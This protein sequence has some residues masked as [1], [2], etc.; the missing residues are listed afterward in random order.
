MKPLPVVAVVGRPNVGKSALFNRLVGG[1]IAIVE[2]EPGV[3]RDRL[4]GQCRWRGRTF[5]LVDTGGIDPDATEDLAAQSRRHAEL[6]VQEADVI[7]LVVDGQ[8]GV[9]P[10][11]AEVAQLLRRYGKPVVVAVNKIDDPAAPH[12]AAAY[13]FYGL[14]LGDPV[15]VSALH[16]RNTGELLDRV[17]EHLPEVPPAEEGLEPIR[18][19]VVGRP[20]VGKSSLVNALVGQERSI[21]SPIPGTTRD[22]VDIQL[23]R[24]GTPFVLLDTA[25]MRRRAR[26]DTRVE[27]FSVVRAMRAIERCDVAAVV[28]DAS[29]EL[30]EQDR[31]IVGLVHEAGKGLVLVANKWDLVDGGPQAMGAYEERCRR[32]LSFA[33]Y[34]PVA[35]VSA[36]TGRGVNE[37][38][39]LIELAANNAALRVR[40]GQLNEVLQ[41]AMALRPPPADKGIQPKIYYGVQAA[42]KPPL[43]VLFCQHADHLHF[44]Y[45]RYLENRLREAFGFVGTPIRFRLRERRRRP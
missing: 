39:D 10:L 34:A 29:Q 45:L 6:A 33:A 22:V 31:R 27:R 16:G 8:A 14:G 23:E 44:S 37:V 21:V 25:G 36:L 13:E 20:N 1:R 28:L 17:L 43:F 5:T 4:Y 7:I 38:L 15:P 24:N 41:E 40:T 11:D 30:V 3:T 12:A 26:I 2:D 32:E 19:A 42:V 35:F 9:H 18:V